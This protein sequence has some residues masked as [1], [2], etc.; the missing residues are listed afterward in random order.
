MWKTDKLNRFHQDV[1]RLYQLKATVKMRNLPTQQKLN[2]GDQQES[3][4]KLFGLQNNWQILQNLYWALKK[5][6]KSENQKKK[7]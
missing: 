6:K 7:T 1:R 3:D 5:R 4:A 2:Y